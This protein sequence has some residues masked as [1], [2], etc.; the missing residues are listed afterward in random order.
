MIAAGEGERRHGLADV[1]QF[2]LRQT[3]DK[4]EQVSDWGAA[5]LS[6][7]QIEYA[8]RDAAIMPEVA[9]KLEERIAADGLATVLKLEN[10]CVMPIAEMELNGFYLDQE[11]WREQLAVVTKAQAKFADELQDMLSA[12]VAQASLFGRAEINLDSQAQVTDALVG[13]GVP[14]PDTTRAWEL[15]PLAEKYPP[16]AKLLEYRAVAKAMSSFG[17][18]ILEFIEPATGRIHADFRQIGAPTGRFS[19]SNPNLQQI[20]HEEEYRRCFHRSRGP[21]AGDRRLFADRAADTGRFFRG[22]EF[23]RRVCLG[24]GFSL[25]DGGT[26]FWHQ[27][28]RCHARTSVRLPNGSI[29]AWFTASGR[30]GSR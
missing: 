5:E 19:C 7:S 24:P 13:L 1:V 15:Q 10:E 20:P 3:L 27:G 8:A 16:V 26:G 28:R 30:R 23:Y 22:Q 4:S 12:G 17:E 14:M 18:N 2:F 11:R 9:E 25:G 29:S 6:P 21:K